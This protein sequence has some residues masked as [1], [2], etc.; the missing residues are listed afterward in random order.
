MSKATSEYSA[1]EARRADG[2][3]GA[4]LAGG[5]SRRMGRDKA[6]IVIDG[7]PLLARTAR[8]LLEVFGE[9]LVVGGER[10]ASGLPPG[11]R[12]LPDERPG[13]GPVG[14]IATALAS[15][16]NDMVFVCACDMP[17]LDTK[18]VSALV[19]AA[20]RARGARAVAPRVGGEVHPLAAVYARGCL[21]AARA[22]LDGGR[23]S[24]REFL[25]E[26]RAVYVDIDVGSHVARALTNVNTPEELAK[27]EAELGRSGGDL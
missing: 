2:F 23:L 17:L 20:L 1:G 18:A 5:E 27:V 24:A 7:E 3:T 22:A 6:E 4:V 26:V 16:S 21:D 10:A 25:E 14:G 13:L 12:A 15:S 11:V 19:D 9:V 8:T